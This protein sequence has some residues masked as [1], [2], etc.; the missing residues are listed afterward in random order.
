MSVRQPLGLFTALR[1][2]C[3][4][5]SA[6]SSSSILSGPSRLAINIRS[7]P[8]SRFISNSSIRSFHPRRSLIPPYTPSSAISCSPIGPLRQ[9]SLPGSSAQSSIFAQVFR[10]AFSSS[11]TGL[12]RQTYFPKN[13]GY[14]GGRQTPPGW[15]SNL[16]RRIDRLPTI[17]VVSYT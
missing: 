3:A 8:S 11:R 9:P 7:I 1:Q 12:V 16:R 14:G 5:S 13:S 2:T 15:F 4:A 6:A 17:A 10:R